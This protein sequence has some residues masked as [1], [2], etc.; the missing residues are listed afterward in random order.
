MLR[1]WDDVFF[2]IWTEGLIAPDTQVG[3]RDGRVKGRGHGLVCI[4]P[5][6]FTLRSRSKNCIFL[7]FLIDNR[8]IKQRSR[9]KHVMIM[10]AKVQLLS[11]MQ[12]Q[13]SLD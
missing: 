10:V 4:A 13:M 5:R 7:L 9:Q 8:A 12:Y 2:C 3:S 6:G 11:R 1:G